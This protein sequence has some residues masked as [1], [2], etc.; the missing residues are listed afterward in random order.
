MKER[1]FVA[2]AEVR[3]AASGQIDGHAAVFNT[4]YTLADYPDFKIIE[5]I[6]PGAFARAIRERHD[7]RCLMNHDVNFLLGRTAS[8]TLSLEEDRRGLYFRCSPP[9]TQVG[10][11]VRTLIERGDIS[12]CSFAFNVTQQTRTETFVGKQMIVRREIS[13]VDLIDVGPVTHP[14]Y[15]STDVHARQVDFRSLFSDGC[16]EAIHLHLGELGLP[17]EIMLRKVLPSFSA[18]EERERL[19]LRVELLRRL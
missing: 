4:D 5:S 13:D 11:D 14:A 3:T 16:P 1:R 2:G 18:A 10:R 17:K 19:R 6:K 12:G 8:K 7:V 9:D 15:E